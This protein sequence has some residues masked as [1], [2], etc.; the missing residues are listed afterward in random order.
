MTD[1]VKVD[2]Q[3][4][5]TTERSVLVSDGDTEVYLPVSQIA[6]ELDLRPGSHTVVE[7]PV[8]LAEERGLV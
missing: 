1:T 3:I 5:H 2:V 6:G 7:I 8:W 4:M